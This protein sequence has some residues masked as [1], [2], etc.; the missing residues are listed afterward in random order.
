M[1]ST[2]WWRRS[3]HVDSKSR[4][5]SW[6]QGWWNPPSPP[7]P[8]AVINHPVRHSSYT[9]RVNA[10]AASFDHYFYLRDSTLEIIGKDTREV[11]FYSRVRG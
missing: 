2:R 9:H 8:A 5:L 3:S 1:D 7:L 10:A 11:Y 6:H 4:V